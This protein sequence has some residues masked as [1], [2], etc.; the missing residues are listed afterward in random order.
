VELYATRSGRDVSAVRWYVVF[1]SWKLG[2]VLQQI[3]V[4]WLR[5]Q[6]RDPRFAELDEAA[7]AL[8]RVAAARRG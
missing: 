6:T 8:F 4:R 3:Y 1:G 2:V 5:G 7:R